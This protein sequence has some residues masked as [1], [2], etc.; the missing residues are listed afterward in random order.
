MWAFSNP[1]VDAIVSVIGGDDSIRM[2]PF[3]DF[4]T[5][6]KNPKIFMGYS[7][8]T[9]THFVCLKAGLCS[10]YGP[11]I[12]AGFGEN[13]GLFDYT[14]DAVRSVLFDGR[15]LISIPE[16]PEWTNEMLDW[17]NPSLQDQK[18][19]TRKPLGRKCLQ[20]KGVHRGHLIGGCAE[21]LE[22]MKGTALW[23]DLSVWKGAILFLETSEEMPEVHYFKR[24]MRNLGEQGI[25]KELNG[26]WLGRPFLTDGAEDLEI[27]DRAL[28]EVVAGEYGLTQIPVFSQMDFGHTDPMCILPLGVQV[29]M[30]CEKM[31]ASITEETV[32]G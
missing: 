32:A 22:M 7:D 4:E 16:A 8:S 15:G 19:K 31:S 1:D 14:I 12:M 30:D 17:S 24:W 3:L 21:V 25:L 27:Y 2:L 20:G 28:M 6:R 13:R 5:I 11:T 18:R 23:P 26:I 9:V 10:Y 29:E